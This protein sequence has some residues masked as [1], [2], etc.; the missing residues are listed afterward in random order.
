MVINALLVLQKIIFHSVK[1]ISIIDQRHNLKF[2][3][4]SKCLSIDSKLRLAFTP[5]WAYGSDC[6]Q[7]QQFYNVRWN[8]LVTGEKKVNKNCSSW[9]FLVLTKNL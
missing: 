7:F 3:T 5:V 2:E 1:K 8:I 4:D 9:E 6:E